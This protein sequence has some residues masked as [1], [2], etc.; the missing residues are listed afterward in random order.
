LVAFPLLIL[1]HFLPRR[2]QTPQAKANNGVGIG[3]NAPNIDNH[4]IDIKY[5]IVY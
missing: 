2:Q 4:T 1:P 5:F 3:E